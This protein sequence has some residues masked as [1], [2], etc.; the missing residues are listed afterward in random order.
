MQP[1]L[2]RFGTDFGNGDLDRQFLPR[3]EQ[4]A[5]Y[6]AE[7]RRILADHPRRVLVAAVSEEDHAALEAARCFLV[8]TAENEGHPVR[9]E[10]SL[11]Q[12]GAELAEDFAV[13]TRADRAVMVHVCFPSG[14]RPEAV[15]GESFVRI[16]R[17][18]PA[19]GAI[20]ERAHG[21]LEAMLTRGPYVRF[22]WTVTADDQLDH[23]PEQG[24]RLPWTAQTAHG[25]LRVERQTTVPLAGGTA[26][27]FL[28]RT[29]LYPFAELSES[30]R[31]IL[32][33]AL[34][35]MPAELAAYKQLTS[36]VP[37]ALQLLR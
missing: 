13:L 15:V 26:S 32:S 19:F 17:H 29:Y 23:H 4:H 6:T 27:L 21:L 2:F 20:A 7:K 12:L 33:E 34:R 24:A 36:A 5:H 9:S 11:A 30:Q 22:V 3:D 28:I 10:L 31:A 37:R 35:Q 18:V 8:Q 25:F 1:G 14:W 16:H